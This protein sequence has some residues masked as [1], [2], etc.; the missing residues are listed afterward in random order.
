MKSGVVACL[1][2]RAIRVSSSQAE[3]D[4]ELGRI[5]K[6]MMRNGYPR[7]CISKVVS[8]Q[9]KRHTT[10][11]ALKRQEQTTNEPSPITVSIPFVEGLSQEVRH[12]ACTSGVR[13]A[14]F[15][16]NTLCS[17]YTSKDRLPTDSITS[18][19]YSMKCK[20]CSGE[21]VGEIFHV[22]RVQKKEHCDAIRVG[23]S[24]KSAIAEHVHEHLMPHEIDWQG[25]KAIDHAC[26]K[27]ERKIR[28]AFHIQKRKLQLNRDG[29]VEQSAI[30][31]A[32]IRFCVGLD[33]TL[34]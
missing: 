2:N 34:W 24:S 8:S 11:R 9:I 19:V 25:M 10:S 7:K 26:W 21:C 12:I 27:R 23:K 17:L 31:N 6:V 33:T 3:T 18:A 5:Q 22:L 15:T 28:E 32:I 30:S 1:A 13:C 29:S 4:A 16:P 14:F 20:M